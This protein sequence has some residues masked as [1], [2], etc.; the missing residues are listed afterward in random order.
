LLKFIDANDS[1]YVVLGTVS[2]DSGYNTKELKKMWGLADTVL[3]SG[4]KYYICSKVIEAEFE[5]LN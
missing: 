2:V 1:K 5:E 4:D 3:R